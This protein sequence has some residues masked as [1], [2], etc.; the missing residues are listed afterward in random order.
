MSTENGSTARQGWPNSPKFVCPSRSGFP[1][2]SSISLPPIRMCAVDAVRGLGAALGVRHRVLTGRQ[3]WEM[4]E[5]GQQPRSWA[6]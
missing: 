1:V 4:A 2:H 3:G 6:D 5:E